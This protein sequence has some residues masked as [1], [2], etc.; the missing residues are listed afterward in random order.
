MHNLHVLPPVEDAFRPESSQNKRMRRVNYPDNIPEPIIPM[1]YEPYTK[2]IQNNA[3]GYYEEDYENHKMDI[4]LIALQI[5]LELNERHNNSTWL[6]IFGFRS[7]NN[8]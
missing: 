6:R 2:E 1:Q 5:D 7:S 8:S 3:L 4:D